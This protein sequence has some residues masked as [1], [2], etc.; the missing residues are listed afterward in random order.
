M[1]F[2][3][4]N[5]QHPLNDKRLDVSNLPVFQ[6][7]STASA[8]R[9]SR[10]SSPRFPFSLRFVR[11]SSSIIILKFLLRFRSSS[12]HLQLKETISSLSFIDRRRTKDI[13]LFL[14]RKLFFFFNKK[15]QVQLIYN[16]LQPP[17]GFLF[18]SRMLKP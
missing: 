13:C 15:N 2:K 5:Y 1:H 18:S 3:P 10:L 7:F 16:L 17:P 6:Y 4:T 11:W 12:L 14:P 9:V 8:S